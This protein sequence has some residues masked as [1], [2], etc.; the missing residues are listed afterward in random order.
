MQTRIESLTTEYQEFIGNLLVKSNYFRIGGDIMSVR[1]NKTA[2]LMVG[3]YHMNSP[4]QD[5]F[6]VQT[7]DILNPK[8]QIEISECV[9]LLKKFKPTK[10]AVEVSTDKQ[11]ELNSKF[12]GYLNNNYEL[13]R[14]EGEQLGFR[15]AAEL[16]HKE[17]YAIDWNE[18]TGDGSF[19]EYAKLH[20]K[21]IYDE[22]IDYGTKANRKTE[23]LLKANTIREV[24]VHLNDEK[25][26]A[27]DHQIYLKMCEIGHG[28]EYLGIKWLKGWYERNLIIFSNVLR[29]VTS[30]QDRVLVIYGSGHIPLL[31]QFSRDSGKFQIETLRNYFDVMCV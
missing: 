20:Q 10:V 7:D 1:H 12:R 28:K 31:H 8:R 16:G 24:L 4:N 26:L 23:D 13:N 9:S 19:I 25:N 14:S 2:L 15:I 5:L 3:S 21:D 11:D 6:N 30:K 22:I 17:I 29:I 27:Q 18:G